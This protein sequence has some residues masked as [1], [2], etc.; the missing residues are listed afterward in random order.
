MLKANFCL[1]RNVFP[2]PGTRSRMSALSTCFPSARLETLMLATNGRLRSVPSGYPSILNLTI[3]TRER[4]LTFFPP[5]SF[6][7]G[8]LKR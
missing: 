8:T 1:R 5:C 6:F 4:R 7:S 3:R 2:V